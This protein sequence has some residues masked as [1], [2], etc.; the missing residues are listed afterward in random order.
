MKKYFGDLTVGSGAVLL[1]VLIF[2][3]AF[4]GYPLVYVFKEAFWIEGESPSAFFL[5]LFSSPYQMGCIINTFKVAFTATFL[6]ILISLPLAYFFSRYDFK[7][8]Q[9]LSMFLLVPLILP[10]FVGAIG[11]KQ[12]FSRFG[13]LNILLDDIGLVPLEN[14]ID[15]LGGSGFW[16]VVIMQVLH[17]Y[18]ILYLN[19]AAVMAN[20]DPTLREAAENLGSTSRDVFLKVTL[21][22]VTPGIFAGST[23]VFISAFTDLGTPLIFNYRQMIPVQIFDKVSDAAVDPSGYALIILVLVLTALMFVVSKR[24]FGGKGNA[25]LSKGHVHFKEKPVTGFKGFLVY[26]FVIGV[27]TLS[28]LPHLI[29]VLF[30]FSDKWFFTIL[31][32]EWTASHYGE[33]FTLPLTM[34]SIHNSLLYSSLS[35]FVDLILGVSIAWLVTRKQFPGRDWLDAL[36]M[37]PLAL[38]GLVLAFGYVMSFNVD[39]PWLNPRD[40]PMLLLIVAYSV[41]RLPFIVRAAVAGFQQTSVTLEEASRNLGAGVLT[42]LRK[43]TIPLVFANLIAGT[44]LT[45]SFAMLEVSDSLILAMTS[46]SYPIT[47]A[48]Y[49]LMGRVNPEAPAIASAMGVV[50]MLILGLCLFIATRL[51]GKKMGEMFRV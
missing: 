11:L 17:L 47:K 50:G 20:L 7:G 28:I 22:L 48:I 42:T 46:D 6:T 44:I 13:S 19:V 43:I 21:P 26:T 31:P 40:N 8:K 1:T 5:G 23:I 51:L 35:A 4:L 3:A 36:A 33:V 34:G 45:F 10:P 25:T 37:L 29:V 27:I 39:I 49:T 41:R 24:L 14:S 9:V 15:W 12:V 32:T 18:P 38:P 30:S 2:M 16:G